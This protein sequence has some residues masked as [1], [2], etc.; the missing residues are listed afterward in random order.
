MWRYISYHA[1]A[2][3]NTQKAV[4]ITTLNTA[5]H[6]TAPTKYT[7]TLRNGQHINNFTL[8]DYNAGNKSQFSSRYK[9]KKSITSLNT[10]IHPSMYAHM[11]IQT[12]I[13]LH[14]IAQSAVPPA[15]ARRLS[16]ARHLS[17]VFIIFFSN[18]TLWMTVVGIV[19]V[20]NNLKSTLFTKKKL[21]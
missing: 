8:C 18:V 16:A 17:F 19:G 14:P 20:Y 12:P 2:Q 21:Y 4:Y 13:N 10:C 15:L 6:L 9:Q 1:T 11:H 7:V 3:A 5:L